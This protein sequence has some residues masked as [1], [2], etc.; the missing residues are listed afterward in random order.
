MLGFVEAVGLV[1]VGSLFC[2]VAWA[3]RVGWVSSVAWFG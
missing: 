2:L 1:L 3:G